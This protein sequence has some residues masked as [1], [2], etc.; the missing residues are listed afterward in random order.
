MYVVQF[1][2]RLLCGA[3]IAIVNAAFI[4]NKGPN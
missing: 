4:T 2:I 3:V 1:N